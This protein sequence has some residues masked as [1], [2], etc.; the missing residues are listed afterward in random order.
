MPILALGAVTIGLAAGCAKAP[1]T[2]GTTEVQSNAGVSAPTASVPETTA[3]TA[4]TRGSA[5]SNTTAKG[6]GTTTT[7]KPSTSIPD[8][9]SIPGGIPSIPGGAD[10][11]KCIDLATAY[12]GLFLPLSS[13]SASD[14]DIAKATQSLEDIKGKV[15]QNI[16][17]DLDVIENGIKNAGGLAGL[18]QFMS[19]SDFT[20]ANDEI[21]N[22]LST[23]CTQSAGN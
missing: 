16:Q 18:G 21:T 19:S 15:P 22:Y 5:S 20:K 6:S 11:Q 8:I 2:A 4:T 12:S 1:E 9:P 23:T 14:A 17:A 13:G 7:A 10:L 3:R